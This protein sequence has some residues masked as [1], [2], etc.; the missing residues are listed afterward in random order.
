MAYV[1]GCWRLAS[2]AGVA[3]DFAI[4]GIFSHWQ[5]WMAA[6]AVLHL[7]AWMFNRYGRGYDLQIPRI[8]HLP[9]HKSRPD[10]PLKPR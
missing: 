9:F 8:L 10:S 6:G 2:D 1:L 4:G 7:A 5:I 3:G